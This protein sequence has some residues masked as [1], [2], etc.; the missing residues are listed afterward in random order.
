MVFMFYTT[1]HLGLPDYSLFSGQ[2]P[3]VRR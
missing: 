1:T 2:A 3:K